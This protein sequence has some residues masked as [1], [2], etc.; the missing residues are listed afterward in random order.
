MT[1]ALTT[2]AAFTLAINVGARAETSL[3]HSCIDMGGAYYHVAATVSKP[4]HC[5]TGRLQCSHFLST[6]RVVRPAHDQRT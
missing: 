6:T 5:C 2:L 4:E 3:D 1:L